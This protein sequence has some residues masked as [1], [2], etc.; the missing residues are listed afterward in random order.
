MRW[1]RKG[2]RLRCR[3]IGDE[4]DGDNC[5]DGCRG[6]NNSVGEFVVDEV[7]LEGDV[8]EVGKRSTLLVGELGDMLPLLL[9]ML[10][11]RRLELLEELG[12]RPLPPPRDCGVV[13]TLGSRNEEC[14]RP[15]SAGAS[16][17][18]CWHVQMQWTRET[19]VSNPVLQTTDRIYNFQI[20]A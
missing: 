6:G 20:N 7:L 8:G 5:G 9:R 15:P 14:L 10:L 1:R 11:R 3:V 12:R 18:S 19:Q 17:N 4:G 13:G 16:S 2:R